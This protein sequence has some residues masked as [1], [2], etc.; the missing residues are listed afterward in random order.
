MCNKICGY[1]SSWCK[2]GD[3]LYT[4]ISRRSHFGCWSRRFDCS[5][6]GLPRAMRSI[7]YMSLFV[8][9][10]F[11]AIGVTNPNRGNCHFYD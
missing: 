3:E 10:W 4:F 1:C 2:I 5:T 6:A 9:R 8:A 7:V 11:I